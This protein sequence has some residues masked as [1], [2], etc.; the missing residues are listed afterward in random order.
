VRITYDPNADA[1]YI[2]LKED[3]IDESDEI[4]KGIVVDYDIEQNPVGIEILNA[5]KLFGGKR[6]MKVEMALAEVRK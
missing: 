4:A 5:S 2:K 6:E 3:K 1:L